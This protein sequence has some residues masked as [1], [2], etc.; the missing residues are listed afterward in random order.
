MA[1]NYVK[2][3]DL[4]LELS[5]YRKSYL[6]AMEKGEPKPQINN[7]IGYAVDRIANGVAKHARFKNYTYKEEMIGDAIENCIRYLHN[8]NIEK[9]NNAFAYLTMI[10][11]NA[12]FRRINIERKAQYVKYKAMQH[13]EVFD[14]LHAG[15]GEDSI[16]NVMIDLGYSKESRVTMD[17]FIEEYERA[18]KGEGKTP[19]KKIKKKAGVE[20]FIPEDTNAI[21]E[22]NGTPS[23]GID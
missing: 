21:E 7:K 14:L 17:I 19:V 4:A 23:P 9:T 8:F 11:W 12:F 5:E 2:N 13:S 3:S 20:V 15:S 6:A 18:L 1:N 16:G 22:G 10:C